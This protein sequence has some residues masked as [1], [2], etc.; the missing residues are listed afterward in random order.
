V[1]IRANIDAIHS[2]FLGGHRRLRRI[3]LEVLFIV[4]E[5]SKAKGGG[6]F[7]QA[8]RDAFVTQSHNAQNGI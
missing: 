6:S 1:T 7:G 3:D 5:S 8:Q 2:L 4:I